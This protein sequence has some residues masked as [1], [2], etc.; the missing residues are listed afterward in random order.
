MKGS[1]KLIIA[2][3]SRN[4]SV[5]V[6][7]RLKVGRFGCRLLF[8]GPVNIRSGESCTRALAYQVIGDE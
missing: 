2:E 1:K 7:F 5:K 4:L 6:R 3:S 8:V